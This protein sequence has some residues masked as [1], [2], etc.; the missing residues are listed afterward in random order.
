MRGR[1]AV[2]E[3]EDVFIYVCDFWFL[4]KHYDTYFLHFSGIGEDNDIF[5]IQIHNILLFKVNLEDFPFYEETSLININHTFFLSLSWDSRKNSSCTKFSCSICLSVTR[6]SISS[7]VV[8]RQHTD[9]VR[10]TRG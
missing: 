7:G 10:L 4:K 5:T 8:V 6:E 1:S 3:R 2:D 9:V